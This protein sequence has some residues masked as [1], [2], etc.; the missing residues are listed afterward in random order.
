MGWELHSPRR[1]DITW[2]ARSTKLNGYMGI[3]L[4]VPLEIYDISKVDISRCSDTKKIPR[5]PE[6]GGGFLRK[7]FVNFPVDIYRKLSGSRPPQSDWQLAR[8][9]FTTI[10][11]A[12]LKCKSTGVE[13]GV[14]NYH[15]PCM[16][17]NP[18]VMTIHSQLAAMYAQRQGD[19]SRGAHG[20][21]QPGLGTVGT[22]PTNGE[23]DAQ[24][25]RLWP[26]G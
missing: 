18:K 1:A 8:G 2:C 16:F 12:T 14:A 26:R 24:Q 17:R 13:F 6:K 3:A 7:Y 22:S 9:R 25:A 11:Y 23:L 5:E 21:F 20:R 4:A 10:M 15:M 19:A